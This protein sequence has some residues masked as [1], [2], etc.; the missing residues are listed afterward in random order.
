MLIFPLSALFWAIEVQNLR[1]CFSIVFLTLW[2]IRP[3]NLLAPFVIN[4]NGFLIAWYIVLPCSIN[5]LIFWGVIIFLILWLT[6]ADFWSAW[7]VFLDA[8]AIFS[9]I[10]F[11]TKS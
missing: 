1:P 4:E 2:L 3:F 7:I 6:F 11:L 8:S 10:P 5:E 9:I